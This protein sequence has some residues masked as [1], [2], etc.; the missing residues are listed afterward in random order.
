MAAYN[1]DVETSPGPREDSQP[2]QGFYPAGEWLLQMHRMQMHWGLLC[3]DSEGLLCGR[4]L[5]SLSRLDSWNSLVA[6]HSLPKDQSAKGSYS[7]EA[8]SWIFHFHNW[9]LDLHA[10][11]VQ[12]EGG[13]WTKCLYSSPVAHG[14]GWGQCLRDLEGFPEG[15]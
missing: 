12:I 7:F 2:L 10:P 1:R 3:Q 5:F 11:G 9:P 4:Y 8:K 6:R 15:F 13:C 14:G